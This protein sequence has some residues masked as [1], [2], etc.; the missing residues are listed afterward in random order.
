MTSIPFRRST[1]LNRAQE[2]Q[3]QTNTPFSALYKAHHIK[4]N[5]LAE[6]RVGTPQPSV[7]G[8]EFEDEDDAASRGEEEG[9]DGAFETAPNETLCF[10][11]TAQ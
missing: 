5:S 9:F 7:D 10:G 11:S 1:T 3:R 8:T 6:Q 4:E 2:L